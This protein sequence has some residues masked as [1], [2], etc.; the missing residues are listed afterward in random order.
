MGVRATRA[1]LYGARS[2][3]SKRGGSQ[4]SAEAT[5]GRHAGAP[6]SALLRLILIRSASI[7]ISEF[8]FR[9][10]S[11]M[12]TSRSHSLFTSGFSSVKIPSPQAEMKL[13]GTARSV[14]DVPCA[15]PWNR[16]KCCPLCGRRLVACC[17]PLLSS[18]PAQ[19]S[20]T[21]GAM[22][23]WR[24]RAVEKALDRVGK[25]VGPLEVSDLSSLGHLDQ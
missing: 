3:A 6:R 13:G 25:A 11:N 5:R 1:E 24:V 15:A 2:V 7:S 20:M 9:L 10:G 18:A 12:Y 22:Y 14:C 16:G 19:L 17:H 8:L 4:L 21:S 23:N